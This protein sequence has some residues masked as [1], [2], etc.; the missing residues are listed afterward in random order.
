[1]EKKS[2]L[3]GEIL[4]AGAS[5]GVLG[6]A[7]LRAGP[8]SLNL[9]LWV[10]LVVFGAMTLAGRNH[11]AWRRDGVWLALPILLFAL[12]FAWRDSPSLKFLNLVAILTGFSVWSLALVEAR[13]SSR[14]IAGY[15]RGMFDCGAAA[16]I[17]ATALARTELTSSA[18]P[19]PAALRHAR[20][21]TLGT[22]IAIPL[23]F[24]FG[25]LLMAADAVFDR[26]VTT[27]LDIDLANLMSHGMLTGFFAWIVCGFFLLIL[28]V[29]R[30]FR[31][32]II[33][34]GRPPVGV[35]EVVLPLALLDL[36][37]LAFVI[38]QVRYLF[39]DASLVQ[40]TVG[41]TYAE[42]ARRGFFELV[43]VTALALPLLLAADW[44][45][46]DSSPRGKRLFRA[47]AG[48]LLV[49]LLI[50]ML[51]AMKRMQLYQSA[52]GLTEQR[53]YTTAFM[54]WLAVVLAWF[55]GTV[56]AGRRRFFATGALLAAFC[57]VAA[58]NLINPDAVVARVNTSRAVEGEEFD[59][60]YV[61]SLSADAVPTL[62]DALPRLEEDE[63]CVVAAR[64]LERWSPPATID[65][66]AW[67]AARARAWRSIERATVRLERS[68]CPQ[69]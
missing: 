36:L 33:R 28:R 18:R 59:A 6:D 1:M 2:R 52:Y 7:L 25:G 43:T 48:A 24:V 50:I 41:L 4:V 39:G 46:A 51:S 44:T 69:G 11:V 68:A 3:A 58:L 45:L 64:L 21:A 22:L 15:A 27:A 54:A 34:I 13:L 67:N 12:A 60:L 8:W 14:G 40:D 10:T 16:L 26:M 38:V 35:T 65:W 32:E 66:R 19:S 20:A 23:L 57:L 55:A 56:L 31:E 5:L 63:G 30:P 53:L 17:G 9:T 42:Y 62:L 47:L 37:F 29:A 61:S 49:L